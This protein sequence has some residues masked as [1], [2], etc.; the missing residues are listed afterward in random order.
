MGIAFK[1]RASD[2]NAA[3]DV[4]KIVS[5]RPFD[6]QGSAGYLFVI[7]GEVGYV[8]SRDAQHVARAEFPLVEV[9][10]EGRSVRSPTTSSPSR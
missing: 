2:L 10:G 5:P 3:L 1:V 4:V 6:K 7:R 8:Y 9:D